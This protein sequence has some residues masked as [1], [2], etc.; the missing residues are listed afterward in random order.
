M[1][2]VRWAIWMGILACASSVALAQDAKPIEDLIQW[3]RKDGEPAAPADFAGKALPD[4]QNAA[5]ELI[6][7]GRGINLQSKA[8]RDLDQVE[9]FRL[10]VG[11][12]EA[13]VYRA[14]VEQEAAT[15]E[16]V[17]RGLAKREVDWHVR[18][19]APAISTLIPHVNTSRSLANLLRAAAF[20]ALARRDQREA[21][22]RVEQLL[23]LAR[24]LDEDPF[25]ISHQAANGLGAIACDL[26]FQLVPELRPASAQNPDDRAV[27]VEQVRALI[28]ELLDERAVREGLKRGLQADRMSMLDTAHLLYSGRLKWRDM[29][30][31]DGPSE[32]WNLKSVLVRDS[33]LMSEQFGRMIEAVGSPDY[34]T[35]LKSMPPELKDE[36][37]GD[38]GAHPYARVM[39]PG[40]R[41]AALMQFRG[42]TERRLAANALAVRWA[43]LENGGRWPAKLADLTPKHLAK[44]AEDPMAAGRA[45]GYRADGA[46]VIV[47]SVGEDGADDGGSEELIPVGGAKR[48]RM[49]DVVVWV[50]ER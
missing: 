10:T 24:L 19:A 33:G 40:L 27:T 20:D 6:E 7:A 43:T 50:S 8:W 44:V 15:L 29:V 30:G 4:A 35:F 45:L 47:Y 1:G 17:D 38:G 46:R 21:V 18:I 14:L 23:R 34:P 12:T 31:P 28:S 26:I 42:L 13:A 11:A 2:N 36:L 48:W 25:L 16:L 3:L 9:D 41:R 32:P 49:R 37:A 5:V 22:R 39:M